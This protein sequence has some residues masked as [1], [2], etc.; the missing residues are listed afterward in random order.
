MS[1]KD[2]LKQYKAIDREIDRLLEE[3]QHWKDLALR[4]TPG[5]DGSSGSETG[6]ITAV[7]RV[8]EWEQRIDQKVHQLV[9]LREEMEGM[10]SAV[11]DGTQKEILL[12]RYINGQRWESIADE[13]HLEYRWVIRLHGRALQKLTPKSHPEM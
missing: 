10:I 6:R 13:M 7:E 2:Y 12:R 4:V 9:E 1:V 8:T 11:E 5:Y 3:Q